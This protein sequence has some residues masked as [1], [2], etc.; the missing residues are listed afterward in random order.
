VSSRRHSTGA[1]D[2]HVIARWKLDRYARRR[3]TGENLQ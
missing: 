2:V 3:G 1:T